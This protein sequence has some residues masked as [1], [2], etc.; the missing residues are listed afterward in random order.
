MG[1]DNKRLLVIDDDKSIWKVYSDV[2]APGSIPQGVSTRE[3]ASILQNGAEEIEE[4]TDYELHFASQGQAGFQLVEQAL[5]A[6]TPFSVVFIDIRMPPGWDGMETATRIR[7]IDPDLEVVIVTAYTDRSRSEI[8]RSVGAPEKLLYLKKPFDPE[9]LTQVALS[10]SVKWQLGRQEKKQRRELQTV[11][12]TT[13]AAIFTVDEARTIT[14]W[15]PAAERI[16]GFGADEVVGKSCIMERLAPSACPHCY[17]GEETFPLPC[18]QATD[19][20][21]RITC[22]DGRQRTIVKSASPVYDDKG[23][24]QQCVESFWDITTIEETEAALH[25]SE[26]RFRGLIETTS[27]WVWEMDA[28][29]RLTYCSPICEVI[30]GFTPEELLGRDIYSTILH[31][32][33]TAAYRAIIDECIEK[34]R[35]YQGVERRSMRKDGTSGFVESSGVPVLGENGKVRGFRG[36]DR[37]ISDRKAQ[38]EEKKR[39][40]SQY[41]QSQKME[42]LGTLAGGIAHDLNNILTPIMGYTQLCLARQNDSKAVTDG[43]RIIEK[44]GAKAAE[45]IRQILAFSRKQVMVTTNLNLNGLIDNFTKMLKRLIRENVELRLDLAN[46]LWLIDGDTGQVE[47]I[48]VNLVVNARDAISD[49]GTILVATGN[50]T[51]GDGPIYDVDQNPVRSGDFVVMSVTD[52]GCGISQEK[53]Q[54]IFEPFFT[55]KEAG[56]G[57]GIGLS[58]VYGIARQHGAQIVVESG[59]GR[60]T[61]F[62]IYFPRATSFRKEL[63]KATEPE[64]VEGGNEILL[65]VEDNDE[66]RLITKFSLEHYGYTVIDATG[67]EEALALFKEQQENIDLL[68]TDVVMPGFGGRELAAALRKLRPGLP[69]LFMSGHTFDIDLEKLL[70]DELADFIQK[71]F[72]PGDIARKIRK[73]LNTA[74]RQPQ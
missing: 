13:P 55:T 17:S 12:R 73:I 42:A 1:M 54:K 2:L 57:T 60:G 66:V 34:G 10:L 25:A 59:E 61:T 35:D 14:S 11:L 46:D 15:N 29:G 22:R 23:N 51:V 5:A 20:K 72:N 28:E 19:Y 70:P 62:F 4:Q 30:Y 27:D 52:N 33:D 63:P 53:L 37:D 65:L 36:I 40:E 67:G 68:L 18:P 7:A 3:L 69:L 48:L 64:V 24:F 41:L 58:T 39:L 38:E 26:T 43:L 74:Q 44:S 21:L 6:N 56:K 16:T 32:G 31:P 50:Q 49:S 9:E 47:Q 45:L 8:V 71:P